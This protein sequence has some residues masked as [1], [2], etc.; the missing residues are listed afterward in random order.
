MKQIIFASIILS[1]FLFA[2]GNS[3]KKADEK[4]PVKT[5]H[6]S[7]L[8][9]IDSNEARINS[10]KN[11]GALDMM[12]ATQT[13]NAYQVFVKDFPADT[14]AALYIFRSADI[15]SSAMHQYEASVGCL[16]KLIRDYPSFKKLPLCY[17]E[18]GVIYDDNLNDDAKAKKYYEEFLKKYPDHKLAPQVQALISYLGKSNEDLLK[19]FEKKNKK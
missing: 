2:C 10:S 7:L 15:Y 1:A 8:R 13:V 11:A 6:D 4:D 18:L 17:F 9:I 16:E 3:T 19:E 12:L 5:K 14:S